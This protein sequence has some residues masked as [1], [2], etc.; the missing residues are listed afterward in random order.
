[1][2][3]SQ[4]NFARYLASCRYSSRGLETSA[5]ILRMYMS[6]RIPPMYDVWIIVHFQLLNH[7]IQLNSLIHH[8][9]VCV[10]ASGNSRQW[11]A[12]QK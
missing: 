8:A 3:K 11:Q 12:I 7:A 10:T 1:M 5:E 4:T 9:I 6:S 2:L